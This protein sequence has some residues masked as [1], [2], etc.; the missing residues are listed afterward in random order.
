MESGTEIANTRRLFG[1]VALDLRNLA[2]QRQSGAAGGD[3]DMLP[4]R[5][6]GSAG[7]A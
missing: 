7:E 4:T 2:L 3:I 6:L 5:L 1:C